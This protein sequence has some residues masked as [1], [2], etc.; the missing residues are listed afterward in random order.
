MLPGISLTVL[1]DELQDKLRLLTATENK[2]VYVAIAKTD[3][4]YRDPWKKVTQ[5]KENRILQISFALLSLYN[6]ISTAAV[7]ISLT[8]TY[9]LTYR[10]HSGQVTAVAISHP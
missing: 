10:R 4:R 7:S 3:R 9:I 2:D 5:E 6:G 1:L 8:P